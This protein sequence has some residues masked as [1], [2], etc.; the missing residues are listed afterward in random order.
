MNETELTETLDR[1]D[2][3]GVSQDSG[4]YAL[5]VDVPRMPTVA[6]EQWD[7]THETRPPNDALTRLSRAGNVVYVGAASNVYARLCDHAEGEVRQAMLLEAFDA[8]GVV[9]VWPCDN[10]QAQEYNRAKRLAQDGWLCW[11]DGVVIE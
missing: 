5:A 10:P 3:L 8:T 2:L 9:G 1:R 11:S 4:T 6:R 7:A